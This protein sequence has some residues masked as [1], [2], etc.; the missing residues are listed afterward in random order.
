MKY[1]LICSGHNVNCFLKVLLL[2]FI[3]L[4]ILYYIIMK[5]GLVKGKTKCPEKVH[6]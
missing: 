6:T 2:L 5:V 3:Y 1:V 4:N